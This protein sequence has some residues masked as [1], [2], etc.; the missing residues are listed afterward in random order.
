MKQAGIT[1]TEVDLFELHDAYTIMAALC[2]GRIDCVRIITLTAIR[3]ELW[4]H[5]TWDGSG[6]CQGGYLCPDRHTAHH[7]LRRT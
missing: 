6:T 4:V 7:H 3:R 1:H 5:R 2:L